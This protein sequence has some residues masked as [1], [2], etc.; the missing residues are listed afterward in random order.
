MS[1]LVTQQR[2]EKTRVSSF[3]NSLKYSS[4]PQKSYFGKSSKCIRDFIYSVGKL[5]GGTH[6]LAS[7]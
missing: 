5:G 2:G 3:G 4:E 6:F 1:R 7:L